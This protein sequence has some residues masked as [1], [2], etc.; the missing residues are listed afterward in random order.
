MATHDQ[1]AV[2]WSRRAKW[3]PFAFLALVGAGV[4]WSSVYGEPD[5][6]TTKFEAMADGYSRYE[7]VSP[8][9]SVLLPFVYAAMLVGLIA[10]IV[11]NGKAG[12][13]WPLRLPGGR[14]YKSAAVTRFEKAGWGCL[15]AISSLLVVSLCVLLVALVVWVPLNQVRAIEVGPEVVRLESVLRSWDERREDVTRAAILL[16]EHGRGRQGDFVTVRFVMLFGN[17]RQHKLHR[18]T[19]AKGSAELEREIDFLE[20]VRDDLLARHED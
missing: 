4:L 1:R 11:S 15:L 20:R 6:P 12:H 10:V 16:D 3:T 5:K 8:T 7:F 14:K 13:L 9:A 18:T 19:Y 2:A 17:D